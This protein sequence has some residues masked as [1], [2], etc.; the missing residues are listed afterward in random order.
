[1]DE[2]QSGVCSTGSLTPFLLHLKE[3]ERWGEI[4]DRCIKLLAFCP[5]DI[6]TRTLLAEAY[7]EMGFLC[8]AEQE[9]RLIEAEL[10]R[11][12][13]ACRM[14]P[15]SFN[16]KRRAP[17]PTDTLDEISDQEEAL[18]ASELATPTIAELY[19]SQGRKAEAIAIYEKMIENSPRDDA[20]RQRLTGIKSPLSRPE[21]SE[22]TGEETRRAVYLTAVLEDWLERIRKSANAG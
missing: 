12:S 9:Y 3:Q 4:A 8:S 15:A 21:A 5:G 10:K 17:D 6:Q 11:L 16:S 20:I 2:K 18:S 14:H 7:L 22:P 19:L 13:D 1:M